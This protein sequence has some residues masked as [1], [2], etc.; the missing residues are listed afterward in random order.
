MTVARVLV[1]DDDPTVREGVVSYLRAN[2]HEVVEAEAAR[3]PWPVS[4]RS[5]TTWPSST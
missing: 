2:E 4:A 3:P 1:V 5:R